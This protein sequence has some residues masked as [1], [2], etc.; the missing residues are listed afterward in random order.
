MKLVVKIVAAVGVVAVLGAG[1][2]YAAMHFLHAGGHKSAAKPVVLPPKPI[3]FADLAIA[4]ASIAPDAN[5]SGSSF[6]TVDIQFTTTDP[7]ALVS[8]TALQPIIKSAVLN[9]LLSETSTQLQDTALRATLI[10]N[11]LAVANSILLKNGYA[12][13]PAPN[14]LPAASNTGTAALT[15]QVTDASLLPANDGP[16]TVSFSAATGWSAHNQTSG[17]T[18][19]LGSSDNLAFAGLTVTVDGVPANGDSF[20]VTPAPFSAGYITDLVVQD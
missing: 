6:A 3:L 7:N 19:A 10:A 2:T 11:S 1:G 17:Q 18:Y 8:F 5:S 20:T 14:T 9:L 16:F 4:A 12:P 13:S 15:E